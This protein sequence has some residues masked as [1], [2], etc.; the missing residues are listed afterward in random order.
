[1]Q[2]EASRAS[3][4]QGQKQIDAQWVKGLCISLQGQL[5]PKLFQLRTVFNAH[6]QLNKTT[7]DKMKLQRI[8]AEQTYRCNVFI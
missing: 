8:E 3:V 2:P 7:T 6:C 4:G 1:M 5:S